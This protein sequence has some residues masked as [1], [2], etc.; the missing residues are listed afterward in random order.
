MNQAY[1]YEIALR[2]MSQGQYAGAINLL[3]DLLAMDPNDAA[4]HGT[5]ASCLLQQMR[6]HA[7]EY[8]LKIAL[9]L[10]PNNPSLHCIAARIYY[11]QNKSKAALAACDEALQL[12]PTNADVFEL[13]SDILIA[14]KQFK[15]GFVYLQKMAELAPDSIDTAYSFANYY[16]QT[17]DNAKALEFTLAALAIDAQHEGAN[18]LMGRLQLVDG[19][20]SEAEYHARLA[21]MLNPSSK[22][23]LQLFSD[24]KARQNMFIG[25]W[26]KFNSKIS[27]LNTLNQVAILVFGYVLFNF[28]GILLHDLGYHQSGKIVNF[29]W[30]IIVVYSW[31]GMP[32]YQRMLN[33]EIE[34]FSFKA[35]Y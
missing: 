9:Q 18:I 21:I 20:I 14:T 7:A 24:V 16:F 23:A 1:K 11:Y 5:L 8:E 17:G 34:Q 31:L 2:L 26:W 13:K 19:N 30:L 32:L 22:Q 15:E 3:K 29:S 33:K 10:E 35:D 12:D 6:I 27:Q 28:L 25:L 4:Y